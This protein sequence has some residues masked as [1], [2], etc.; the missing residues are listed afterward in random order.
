VRIAIVGAGPAGAGLAALLARRGAAV[1]LIERRRD[2][3]R[4]FRGEVLM[5]SGVSALEQIDPPGL[6]DGLPL[7]PQTHVTVY[8]RGRPVLD[9]DLPVGVRVLAISQPA[10]LE[11]LVAAAG[12][13]GRFEFLRGASV[14]S[15]SR[16]GDRIRGVEITHGGVERSIAADLV[17]GADGRHS[18]VRRLAALHP[19]E[20]HPP[21]D[22]VWGKLPMPEHWQGVSAWA[23]RG[24]LLIAYRSWDDRLQFG[25]VILKGTFGAL[26]ARGV[27]EWVEAMAS[28]VT[29]D[30]ADHLRAHAH[31][32]ERPFLLEAASDR[33]ACWSAP[34]VLLIGDAAHTMSPV[35]AQ[36]INVALRDAIVAANHLVPILDRPE[37][38]AVDRAL[39]AIERERLPE[40][41][42]IQALQAQ[43]PR[44][45]LSRA[46]WAEPLRRAAAHMLTRATARTAFA[47]VASTFA[48]GVTE[49][50]L[51]V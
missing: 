31:S 39:A 17:I 16:D 38:A 28:H 25:W 23:D 45:I 4:E 12:T 26:R 36:G 21:M 22:V 18:I 34:G 3:D 30:F 13:A 51:E 37:R 5:P 48:F 9:E 8:L 33:V 29:P 46:W 15:L 14:R 19:V 20:L 7:R 43:P 32:V 1:T 50:K 35:G 42:R 10:L 6:F 11:R 47:G 41:T 44:L 2:F 49:V 27:G 40:V 24:H